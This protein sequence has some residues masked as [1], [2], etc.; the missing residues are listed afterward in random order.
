MVGKQIIDYNYELNSSKSVWIRSRTIQDCLARSFEYLHICHKSKTELII[1]KLDFEKAFDKI[2]HQAMLQI[3]EYKGFDNIWLGWM[4]S[5]FASGRSY[6]ILNGVPRKTFHCKR[7]VRQGD[8]LSPLLFVLATDFLQF[9]LN[10]AKDQGL[11]NLPIHLRH[12]TEFSILKYENDTLIIMEG[13]AR[14]L[15]F[16]KSLLQTFAISTGLKVYYSKSMMV[17]INIEDSKLHNLAPTFSC[18]TGSMPF[19]Y[20]G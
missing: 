10:K 1:L 4:R 8:P 12:N 16:L 14:Q 17:P 7:G 13:C 9:L 19:T 6:V 2:E 11:M 15:F 20:L 5:I 3:M 18:S